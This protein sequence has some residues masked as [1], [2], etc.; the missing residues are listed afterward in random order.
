MFNKTISAIMAEIAGGT[1]CEDPAPKP[2]D[3]L[4]NIAKALKE[5]FQN[6][7]GHH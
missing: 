4:K 5:D 6:F 3:G 1:I 2:G 7:I